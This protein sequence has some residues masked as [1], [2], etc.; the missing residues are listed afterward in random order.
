MTAVIIGSFIGAMGAVLIFVAGIYFVDSWREEK[1][2]E[3]FKRMNHRDYFCLKC[4][5]H[6]SIMDN[7][8]EDS[9]R[10]PVWNCDGKIKQI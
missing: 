9:V 1:R 3:Q 2:K 7:W 5:C 4:D 8:S 10:C 6:F